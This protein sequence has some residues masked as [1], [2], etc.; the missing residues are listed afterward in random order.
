MDENKFYVYSKDGCGYCDRL[1]QFMDQKG[2]NYEK[3]T[4]DTDFTRD[5]FITKFGYN[6]TFPQVY[7]ENKTIGGMKSTVR[8]LLEHEFV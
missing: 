5:E 7:H 6:S 1:T 2:V 4:L 8:Y 3:F